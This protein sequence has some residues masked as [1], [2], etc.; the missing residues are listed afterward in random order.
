MTF[1]PGE[2]RSSTES[3]KVGAATKFERE[4]TFSFDEDAP[5]DG[6]SDR[7]AVFT[8]S[9]SL[10]A[11]FGGAL[12]RVL[13][14]ETA[15]VEALKNQARAA[16]FG[17]AVLV[18]RPE[19]GQAALNACI[20]LRE[21]GEGA[22]PVCASYPRIAQGWER[23]E[24]TGENRN[25]PRRVAFNS[26]GVLSPVTVFV[27]PEMLAVPNG[28]ELTQ[29]ALALSHELVAVDRN[30]QEARIEPL[31]QCPAAKEHAALENG[32]LKL[33]LLGNRFLSP[34]TRVLDENHALN[35]EFPWEEE[36]ENGAAGAKDACWYPCR[37][38]PSVLASRSI[39]VDIRM[40]R[41]GDFKSL[42]STLV[43]SARC[44]NLNLTF[45]AGVSPS[46][47]AA[48]TSMV[49]SG[50]ADAARSI[51]NEQHIR[52]LYVAEAGVTTNRSSLQ[53][54]QKAFNFY[55]SDGAVC[56]RAWFEAE[57][58]VGARLPAMRWKSFSAE[59]FHSARQEV[60][61]A[62]ERC[63]RAQFESYRRISTQLRSC[64]IDPCETL[65]QYLLI[66]DRTAVA[67][68]DR[69][70]DALA[71]SLREFWNSPF[72]WVER[73]NGKLSVR[74]RGDG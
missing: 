65:I 35:I 46:A 49:V 62:L 42:M 59:D 5:R 28:R 39:I 47:A 37:L 71:P 10:P 26:P 58:E 23:P 25:T 55:D 17:L 14:C 66:D 70:I 11:E 15:A 4:C 13:A 19:Q 9:L 74:H 3:R 56:G 57:N 68:A 44:L 36:D 61:A 8:I 16:G 41:D 6:G 48:E 43:R 40:M 33:Q 29:R 20:F 67:A 60:H 52:R 1:T 45:P 18:D 72:V 7:T 12:S 2:F 69:P 24:E 63:A 34:H 73:R 64:N 51:A 54:V 50:L 38:D 27:I 32:E 22:G 21:D 31:R 30:L 53:R